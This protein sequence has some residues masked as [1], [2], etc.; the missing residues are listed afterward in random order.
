MK[1]SY[2]ML[3]AALLAGVFSS[4]LRAQPAGLV[5][6]VLIDED[7]HTNG[8]MW[9]ES[10]TDISS[11]T[12]DLKAGTYTL[13]RTA[14][15]GFLS[16]HD[17]NIN[18]AQDFSIEVEMR[19]SGG[20]VWGR[21]GSS[22]NM[23]WLRPQ[24]QPQPLVRVS[25]IR[26][27]TLSTK[28]EQNL[29]APADWHTLRVARV[30]TEL[31]YELDGALV[32][33]QPWQE[34]AGDDVGFTAQG[35]D[36]EAVFRRLRIR[37]LARP[38]RLAPGLPL[39]QPRE[40]LPQLN[41]P[42]WHDE[43][44]LV[45]ADGRYMVTSRL[46]NLIDGG[47]KPDRDVYLA[48]RQAD[49]SWGP[50]Q[51]VGAPINN[52]GS[53][54][55][56]WISAD[57]QELLVLSRYNADG[58]KGS[59]AGTSRVRRGADG[60]W[61]VPELA[62]PR[63]AD[64]DGQRMSYSY[65]V[66]NTLRVYGKQLAAGSEDSDLFVEFRQADGSYGPATSLGPTLNT[67]GGR[68][69][70]P[71]LAPD[72]QTLYFSSSG[73]PGYGDVDIFVTRRLDD[74]WTKWSEPLNL[75]PAVNTRGYESNF[76]VAAAGDYAYYNSRGPEGSQDIYRFKLVP[77]VAP[78]PSRL[79]KGRVLDARTGASILMA[80][81]RYER[82][83]DGQEAGST[84]LAAGTARYEIVLPGGSQYGFRASA[85]GY[86]SVNQNV[87]LTDLK[88]YGE[89][90]QDLLLMPILPPTEAL[91]ATAVKLNMGSAPAVPATVKGVAAPQPVV[92]KEEKISLN[93][94]F[95]VQSKP[96]LLPGSFPELARL[97]QTL[98]E[99]PGLRIRLDGH[100]DNGGDPKAN[101]VLSQQRVAAIKAYLIKLGIDAGRL[102]TQGWGDTRPVA[103]N[104]TEA[105][106]RK[107]RRVEFVIVSR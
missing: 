104:D 32:L 36:V 73:H 93:N 30:G 107:N 1:L 35:Q 6:T 17:F 43:N 61:Q 100:T 70:D 33:A 91:T 50:A 86:V 96:V 66:A 95:F 28:A 71:F 20:V 63:R 19:G 62:Y 34:P 51:G 11:K 29:P 55:A 14:A 42:K 76:T 92:V 98:R 78:K 45:S 39:A 84:P 15:G 46:M 13:R 85:S 49:G 37:H 54:T 24:P 75:G 25:E 81:V 99:N 89:V 59:G 7:F 9:E 40:R 68:E 27:N 23:F 79:V 47:A 88:K 90:T 18:Y 48:E 94:V 58:S 2:F 5:P 12:L 105:N 10:K 64:F 26:D 72:G 21:K 83:P 69:L 52:E 16:T 87:D 103:Q 74:S 41:D 8:E 106:K 31:R 80:E 44:P 56:N 3:V 102:D 22:S 101:L 38:V 77:S 60:R 4:G 67:V 65:D 53:N 57:G 97:A 82:L